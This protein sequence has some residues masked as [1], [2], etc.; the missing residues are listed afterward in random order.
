MKKIARKIVFSSLSLLSLSFLIAGD[1]VFS[2]Y[3][4][5]AIGLL[6]PPIIDEEYSQV[7]ASKGRDLAEKIEEEGIV[8]VKNDGL[9]PLS[10]KKT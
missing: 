1:V 7:S 3:R 2:K 6:C 4:A 5:D 10:T 8:L 9:L